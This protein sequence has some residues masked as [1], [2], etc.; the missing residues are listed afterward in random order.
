MKSLYGIAHFSA[1]FNKNAL[2]N[3]R[4]LE[5]KKRRARTD[6]GHGN[7]GLSPKQRRFSVFQTV[8]R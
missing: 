6:Y 4:M 2:Q 8:Q 3:T 5:E 1:H 7:D